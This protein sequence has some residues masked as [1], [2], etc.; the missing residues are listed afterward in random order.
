MK[1]FSPSIKR[2]VPPKSELTDK[3]LENP[4]LAIRELNNRSF[5]QFLKFMWPAVSS[6]KFQDNWHI[7]YVCDQLQDLAEQVA[8][9]R[10][11][12]QK[13]R[14]DDLIINVPPGTTKTTMVS[15]MFPAWCWTRWYWMEFIG[16]SY[17]STLS[18]EAAEAQRDLIRSDRFNAVYPDLSIKSD[19]DQK[20]NF[21]L[22]KQMTGEA[23]Y[24]PSEKHGGSRYSTSIG[25]TLTGF[26]GHMILVDDPIN[27]EQAVSQKQ[28]K[29]VNRWLDQTL[30]TRKVHKVCSPVIYVMQRLHEDDPTGHKLDKDK[31][32]VRH[33]CLP[34]EIENFEE[35]VQPHS[36]KK[37]YSEDG[38]LDPLRMT[39]DVLDDLK[40][41]LGQYG[42]AGQVGQSPTPPSGGMFKVDR[43]QVVD[44]RPQNHEIQQIVRYWDKAGTKEKKNQGKDSGAAWTVGCKMAKLKDDKYIILNVVR[45]RWEAEQREDKM[46]QTARAD[47]TDVIIGVEQEPGSGGKE[48]AQATVKNLSGFTVKTDRPTGDK[49]TRADPYSVQVNWRNVM[50]LQGDWNSDFKEEHRFFPFGTF[51]DQVDAAAGA[52]A[53]LN[54]RKKA[55]VIS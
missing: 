14:V 27:P 50:L 37:N 45:G 34:G 4:L 39:W 53:L 2:T 38:L 49:V 25:G 12:T 41:D 20:S 1:E 18:L 6:E 5:Y 47:G 42:Y 8:G 29:N 9:Q 55:R 32:N 48:S 15:I 16:L 19:K 46:K 36:L 44:Q 21:Q 28:L 17:S 31:G 22:L 26:H 52:F 30:P 35:E 43:F 54:K 24:T 3:L 10:S 51:K 13:S 11:Q 7:K 40:A 33:I 23:G